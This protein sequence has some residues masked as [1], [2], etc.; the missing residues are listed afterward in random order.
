M[1]QETEFRYSILNPAFL[2]FG[3]LD[4]MFEFVGFSHRQ[5]FEMVSCV[6]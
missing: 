6:H 2:G 3:Q 4:Q 1:E 5:M